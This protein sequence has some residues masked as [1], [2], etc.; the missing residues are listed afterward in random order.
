M[1]DHKATQVLAKIFP[2]NK[3]IANYTKLQQK[4]QASTKIS[5]VKIHIRTYRLSELVGSRQCQNTSWQGVP[6][7]RNVD[8]K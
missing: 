2:L 1:I 3:Y 8:K 4:N 6:Q 5:L 7:K